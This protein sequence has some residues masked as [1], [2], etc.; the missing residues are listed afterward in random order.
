MRDEGKQQKENYYSLIFS[1]FSKLF[2]FIPSFGFV[3]YGT[4]NEG[5]IK[6]LETRRTPTDCCHLCNF[7]ITLFLWNLSN[8]FQL[9][10]NISNSKVIVFYKLL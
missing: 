2:N 10:E 8:K 4:V 9:K 7:L 5:L 6:S 3:D 1:L